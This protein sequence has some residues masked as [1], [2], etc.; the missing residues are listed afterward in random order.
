M[1]SDHNQHLWLVL[2]KVA[3]IFIPIKIQNYGKENYDNFK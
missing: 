3:K 1:L 2:I